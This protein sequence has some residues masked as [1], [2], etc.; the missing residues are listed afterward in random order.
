MARVSETL[1][2]DSVLALTDSLG[3]HIWSVSYYG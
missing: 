3:M 2:A 1:D